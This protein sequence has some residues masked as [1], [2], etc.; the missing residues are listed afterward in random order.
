MALD[1][2][3]TGNALPPPALFSQQAY[4]ARTELDLSGGWI[5]VIAGCVGGAVL[6]L[7]AVCFVR[8][9]RKHYLGSSLDLL[10]PSHGLDPLYLENPK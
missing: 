9:W 3:N 2:P 1:V 4:G 8:K 5:A 10:R 6:V 7:L